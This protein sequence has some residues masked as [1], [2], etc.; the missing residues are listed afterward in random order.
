[1]PKFSE[2]LVLALRAEL[3]YIDG[4]LYRQTVVGT[5]TLLKACSH[6]RR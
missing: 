5:N 1:M 6:A 2:E 4:E 3:V